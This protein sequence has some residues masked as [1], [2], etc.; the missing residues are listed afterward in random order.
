MSTSSVISG[1]CCAFANLRQSDQKQ[2]HAGRRE[3][4]RLFLL[5]IARLF[6]RGDCSV[7][8]RNANCLQPR[9]GPISVLRCANSESPCLCGLAKAKQILTAE[10]QRTLS[11]H[12]EF[13]TITQAFVT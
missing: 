4:V 1:R 8:R 9:K 12:R 10:S 5:V 6:R 2:K 7:D 3:D 11:E 13:Q